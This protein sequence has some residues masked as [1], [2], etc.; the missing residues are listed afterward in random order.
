MPP[1]DRC[2]KSA[3]VSS[4]LQVAAIFE[5]CCRQSEIGFNDDPHTFKGYHR[6]SCFEFK[7]YALQSGLDAEA[8]KICDEALRALYMEPISE[9]SRA[10]KYVLEVCH[11]LDLLRCYSADKMQ[12]KLEKLQ[13]D[14]GSDTADLLWRAAE[15]AIVATGDRMLFSR[16]Y[17]T[18]NYLE[19]FSIYGKQPQ[20][21]V[22][23]V[24]EA[25][26]PFYEHLAHNTKLPT[27]LPA[28]SK[29]SINGEGKVNLAP[30]I[31]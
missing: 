11:E 24:M 23:V 19:N 16:F 7:E 1:E 27:L 4:A 5:K 22:K 30:V 12:P 15:A 25:V 26:K 2:E 14:I 18:R 21:C 13:R 6:E 28:L 20:E 10:A 8:A 9:Q 3:A 31:K 17:G 29:A